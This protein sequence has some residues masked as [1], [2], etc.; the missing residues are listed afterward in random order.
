MCVPGRGGEKGLDGIPRRCHG[1]RR[2]T[3]TCV[4]TLDSS[5]A[6]SARVLIRHRER[7]QAAGLAAQ[8]YLSPL[9]THVPPI[10]SKEN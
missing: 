7:E 10:K 2:T 6:P 5:S 3:D 1:D 4:L 8:R 9:S